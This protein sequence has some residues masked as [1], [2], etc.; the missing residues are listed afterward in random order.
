MGQKEILQTSKW[1]L[2]LNIQEV[3][4]YFV[5]NIL[6][7]FNKHKNRNIKPLEAIERNEVV[8]HVTIWMSLET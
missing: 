4:I 7:I 8:I 1:V 6:P 3:L 2:Y 5:S